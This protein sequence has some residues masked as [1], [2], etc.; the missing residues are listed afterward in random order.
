MKKYIITALAACLAFAPLSANKKKNAGKKQDAYV[1]QTVTVPMAEHMASKKGPQKVAIKDAAKQLYGE[2]TIL[3]VKKV[4]IDTDERAYIY[5]D[6]N[7]GNQFYGCNGCNAINGHFKQNADKIS[8]SDMIQGGALCNSITGEHVIMNALAEVA[9]MEL[10]SLYNLNYLV[11]K[12]AK[13]QEVM[14][15]RQ[16]N[17]DLLNGPWM[18]KEVE[19]ENVLDKEIRL[20]ID[21][22]SRAVLVQT[23]CN[24]ISGQV[25]IDPTKESDVQFE[26]LKSSHNECEDSDL[27]TRL[28]INLEETITCKKAGNISTDMELVNNEG[29]T[30]IRLQKTQ[31][32]RKNL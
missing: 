3:S 20:V 9:S 15:L 7:N 21:I 32:K 22:D 16:L 28:L 27:E 17:F 12:N 25:H 13:G 6:F 30:V 26:D 23:N 2:W 18:V 29:E 10:Q 24:I 14:R 31:L 19:G 8:F 4:D 1:K 5:L 11:L